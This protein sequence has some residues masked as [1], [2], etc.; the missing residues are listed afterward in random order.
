M[1]LLNLAPDIQEEILF[2]PLVEHGRDQLKDWQ[3]RP[4]AAE[5]LWRYQERRFAILSS[6]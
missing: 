5:T 4:V 6:V 3:V 2:L 1:N